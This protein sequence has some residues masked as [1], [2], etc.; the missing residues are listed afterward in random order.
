[1]GYTPRF[2]RGP[3]R[4]LTSNKKGNHYRRPKELRREAIQRTRKNK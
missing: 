1:M 3:I 4:R 2:E